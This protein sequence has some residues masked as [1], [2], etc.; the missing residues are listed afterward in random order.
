MPVGALRHLAAVAA[1]PRCAACGS[2]C[3]AA[4]VLCA[5]CGAELRSSRALVDGT[6]PGVEL[7]VAAAEHTGCPRE[8]AHAL[9][10]GRRLALARLAAEAIVRACPEREL[11]GAIVPVPAAHWRWRWRGFDPAEEI[12]LA[13]AARAGLPYRPCLRRAGGPRQVGRSRTARIADPPRVRA[14]GAVPRRALVVDD[15]WTTGAT[16]CA[17]AGAL[18]AAGAM[19]V[20]ALT[21]VH[22]R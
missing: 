9:K 4:A 16:L 12:A 18:R 11:A 14:A 5:R 1:P 17:C 7:A 13:L 15:V 6:I 10:F 8:I 20:I 19:E 3:P 2:A 21:F 22:S